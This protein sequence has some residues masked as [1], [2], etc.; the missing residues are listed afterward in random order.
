MLVHDIREVFRGTVQTMAAPVRRRQGGRRIEPAADEDRTSGDDQD[1]LHTQVHL[2]SRTQGSKPLN[3]KNVMTVIGRTAVIGLSTLLVAVGPISSGSAAEAKKEVIN[4]LGNQSVVDE[5][6]VTVVGDPDAPLKIISARVYRVPR[7]TIR[8]LEFKVG[9]NRRHLI[10]KGVIVD[11]SISSKDAVAAVLGVFFY[12]SFYEYIGTISPLI[13]EGLQ[14][15]KN[16]NPGTAGAN[17]YA[18][19]HR[20]PDSLRYVY[21]RPDPSFRKYGSACVFIRKVRLKSGKVWRMDEKATARRMVDRGCGSDG[22]KEI[23][24]LFQRPDSRVKHI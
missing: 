2:S 7:K 18:P 12:N 19:A 13:I 6:K 14:S 4:I 16:G 3:R 15:G 5:H 24:K 17:P 1:E 9:R 8:Q 20:S 22:A 11:I 10:P 21:D 23:R